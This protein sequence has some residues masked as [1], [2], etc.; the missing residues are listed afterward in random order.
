MRR[1]ERR[2]GEREGW[3]AGEGEITHTKKIK[4]QGRGAVADR[5]GSFPGSPSFLGVFFFLGVGYILMVKGLNRENWQPI[6]AVSHKI[7]VA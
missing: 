7:T 1:T 6:P 3:K 2:G 5:I 4:S